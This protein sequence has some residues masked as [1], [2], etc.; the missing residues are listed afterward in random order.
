MGQTISNTYKPSEIL[1][2]NFDGSIHRP[3]SLHG[4]GVMVAVRKG[5]IVV[6]SHLEAGK[7]GE[8][9]CAK[10]SVEK[11]QPLYV[12]AYYRPNK[13]TV[14]AL[15]SLELAL[16]ELQVDINKNPRAGLIVAGDFNA[17]G[18]D[19]ENIT[20]SANAPNKGMC[21]RLL[22]ILGSFELTQFVK[23]PTRHKAILDL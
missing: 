2:K 18:I 23:E 6:E 10:I 1:P 12:C 8:I 7:E 4:G 15:D 20:V 22:N 13:D 19:W 17:P 21:Q 14:S 9:V 11:S 5:M 3:R 16:T